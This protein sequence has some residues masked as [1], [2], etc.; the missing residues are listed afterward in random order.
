MNLNPDDYYS[1]IGK[2][3]AMDVHIN[4]DFLAKNPE[5]LASFNKYTQ[6]CK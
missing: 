3:N 4:R 2:S 6:E 1:V 5:F